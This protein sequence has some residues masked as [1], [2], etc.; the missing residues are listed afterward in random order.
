[1]QQMMAQMKEQMA[2]LPPAARAQMEAMLSGSGLM[3]PA[4]T[5]YRRAGAGKV[6]A[7]ACDRYEGFQNGQ[8]TSEVCTAAPGALGLTASDFAV[9][10]QMAEFLRAIV[11]GEVERLFA[12]GRA[13]Q[14]GFSGIPVRQVSSAGGQESTMEM[15]AVSRQEIDDAVLQVPAGYQRQEFAPGITG[16]A[17]GR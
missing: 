9:V 7:W 15:T 3:M 8:K 6:G 17:P 16:A 12:V 1:M 11:P 2:N 10:E 14:Q 4:P 5:E 13:D